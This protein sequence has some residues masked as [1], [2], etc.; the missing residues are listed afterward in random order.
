MEDSHIMNGAFD[1]ETSLFAIFDGHGGEEVA[2]FAS[3]HFGK[4]LKKNENY[5]QQNFEKALQETFEKID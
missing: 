2:E 5:L 4:E 3:K 1:K